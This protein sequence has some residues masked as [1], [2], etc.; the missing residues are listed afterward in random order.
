VLNIKKSQG[1]NEQQWGSVNVQKVVCIQFLFHLYLIISILVSFSVLGWVWMYA[2]SNCNKR[3]R[4]LLRHLLL[5]GSWPSAVL[6][7]VRLCEEQTWRKTALDSLLTSQRFI[8]MTCKQTSRL[9]LL[10]SSF[11]CWKTPINLPAGIRDTDQHKP[12]RDKFKIWIFL[13]SSRSH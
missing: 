13:Q 10:A 4:V 8:T 7:M 12:A 1:F 11:C 2:V 9:I 5:R 6:I 3:K